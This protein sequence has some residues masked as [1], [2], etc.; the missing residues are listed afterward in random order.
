MDGLHC[1][2]IG[3]VGQD[4]EVRFTA[5]GSTLA[6]C[7]VLVQD[8]KTTD[9]QGQ[10]IRVARFGD[11]EIEDLV[12]QLVKGCEVYVEGRARLK[13]WQGADGV[14]R[15]GL[16]VTAWRL[17]PIGRIGRNG[18]PRSR[19]RPDGDLAEAPEAA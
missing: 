7:S 15:T 18:A 1:A 12:R 6:S 13:T 2:F 17:E 16:D 10:W 19:R 3:R 4:A 14:N 8:S 11:E 5:N 9:G